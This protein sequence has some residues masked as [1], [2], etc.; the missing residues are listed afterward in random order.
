M[1]IS[2]NFRCPPV[3]SNMAGNGKW[4]ISYGDVP[5]YKPPFTSGIFQLAMFDYQR[6]Y[7][8]VLV[9]PCILYGLLSL[10]ITF[11]CGSVSILAPSTLFE[12]MRTKHAGS[13]CPP[14]VLLLGKN[15]TQTQNGG[16][17][18]TANWRTNQNRGID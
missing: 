11:N 8:T 7:T 17:T 5:S 4:T 12:T 3:S 13:H 1:I 14:K 16:T 6:V 18:A 10:L 9:Y 2:G 15:T